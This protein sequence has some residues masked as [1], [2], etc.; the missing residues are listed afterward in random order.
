MIVVVDDELVDVLAA[1]VDDV[2]VVGA[3]VV[4][5][6]GQG[7]G[8]QVPAPTSRPLASAQSAADSTAQTNA[9]PRLPGTQH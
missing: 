6:V 9:P 2:V 1:T 4:V 5:V 3:T 8:T 7:S